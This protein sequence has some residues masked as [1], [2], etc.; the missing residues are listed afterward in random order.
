MESRQINRREIGKALRDERIEK[1]EKNIDKT[2]QGIG[3][4]SFDEAIENGGTERDT[5]PVRR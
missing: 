3:K 5:A 4:I 2:M 1:E